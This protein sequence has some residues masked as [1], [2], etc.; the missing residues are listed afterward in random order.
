MCGILRSSVFEGPETI[1]RGFEHSY[2]REKSV[3]AGAPEQH[4]R[5]DSFPGLLDQRNRDG[6]LNAVHK[7]LIHNTLLNPPKI[8]VDMASVVSAPIAA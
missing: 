2:D 7:C 4:P 5:R 1:R 8:D 3:R 6:L